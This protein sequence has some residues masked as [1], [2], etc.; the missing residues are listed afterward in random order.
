MNMFQAEDDEYMNSPKAG[1][2]IGS[3]AASPALSVY[4][5][6]M[7]A[8]LL[9]NCYQPIKATCE[10][11]ASIPTG[12]SSSVVAHYLLVISKIL[13]LRGCSSLSMLPTS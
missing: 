12:S 8:G 7:L 6:H 10:V 3:C 9:T 2:G 5:I 4:T 1:V 11:T 13:R